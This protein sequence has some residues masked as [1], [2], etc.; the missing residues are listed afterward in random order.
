MDKDEPQDG[1]SSRA[2]GETLKPFSLGWNLLNFD[3][4]DRVRVARVAR[5][6][7]HARLRLGSPVKA[8]NVLFAAQLAL[9]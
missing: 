1:L 4:I 9:F 6:G 7:C 8:T 3:E 2:D 5:H